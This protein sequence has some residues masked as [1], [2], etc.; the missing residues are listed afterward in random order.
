M[1]N[2]RLDYGQTRKQEFRLTSSTTVTFYHAA[3]Y[4]GNEA[5]IVDASG[6]ADFEAGNAYRNFASYLDNCGFEQLQLSAGT[7][8]AVLRNRGETPQT[9]SLEVDRLPVFTNASGSRTIFQEK[10]QMNPGASVWH[11]FSLTS[12][13]QFYIDGC[14]SGEVSTWLIPDTELS[15]FRNGQT[16]Q[17]YEGF[18]NEDANGPGGW[19]FNPGPGSYVL[20]ARNTSADEP[21]ALVYWGVV[22]Y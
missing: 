14:N 13:E 12:G 4:R 2:V 22:V 20:V 7:Y 11:P 6:L 21:H 15:N 8:Y 3:Q 1:Q 9:M 18:S 17:Y 16:F 5:A 10:Q 19:A